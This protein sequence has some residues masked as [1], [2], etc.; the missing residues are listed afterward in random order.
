MP[1]QPMKM[2]ADS[3]EQ[4]RQAQRQLRAM[5][6]PQYAHAASQAVRS[7]IESMDIFA[8]SETILLYHS[9]PDELPTLGMLSSWSKT[10]KIYLPRVVADTLEIGLYTKEEL[11]QGAFGITEPSHSVPPAEIRHIDMAIVPGTAFDCLGNRIGR[12]K[13]YYDRLLKCLDT[14]AIGVCYDFALLDTLPADDHDI[15]MQ[16]VVTPNRII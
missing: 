16:R 3:K 8:T 15:R 14:Y 13:G 6:T 7:K 9:L 10:K 12:G 4:I 5:V 1:N 11:Q 2:K